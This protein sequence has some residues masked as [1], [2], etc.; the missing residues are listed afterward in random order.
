MNRTLRAVLLAL[1]GVAVLA[2]S[3]WGGWW[4]GSHTEGQQSLIERLPTADAVVVS[5]DFAALRRAGILALFANSKA[6]EETEYRD[7]TRQTDFDY[8]KDLDTAVLSVAPTGKYILARGRFHWNKLDA[9]VEAQGG[10]C[11]RDFCRMQGSTPD[12]RISFFPVNADVMALAVS[13]DESAALRLSASS[14]APLNFTAPDAPLW[15]SVPP[16]VLQ[17]AD[18]LPVET[19]GFASTLARTDSV[20]LSLIPGTQRSV[21]KLSVGCRTPT[22]ASD[23]AAQLTK[24]TALLR[25][26]F[27][28]GHQTPNPADLTGVLAAGRFH[29]DA[30]RVF[31][32]WPLERAFLDNLKAQ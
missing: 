22:D 4:Y 19:R 13:A 2:A 16:S 12:R 21:V 14:G 15:V 32:E 29:N 3:I 6:A 10:R 18:A 9:Y 5:V 7:F 25:E 11:D 1:P 17:S 8:T 20:V 31:G 26:T 27:S 24:L 30:N 23:L 28:S